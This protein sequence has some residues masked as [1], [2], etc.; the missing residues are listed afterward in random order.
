MIAAAGAKD[1]AAA[2][3]TATRAR[4][5]TYAA[6]IHGSMA[7]IAPIIPGSLPGPN[8]ELSIDI[9]RSSSS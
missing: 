6:A 5:A 9:R 4:T 1:E 7:P 3:A 2:R 8:G